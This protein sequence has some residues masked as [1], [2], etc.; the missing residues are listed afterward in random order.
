MI[1]SVDISQDLPHVTCHQES[2]ENRDH[3]QTIFE[4][5]QDTPATKSTPENSMKNNF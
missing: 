5:T 4:Q 2:G 3:Q 1:G